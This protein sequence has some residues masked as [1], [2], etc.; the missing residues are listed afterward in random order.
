MHRC[1]TSA[2]VRSNVHGRKNMEKYLAFSSAAL[3]GDGT[4]LNPG[5]QPETT[6][7][8]G[9][10][11]SQR[12]AISGVLDRASLDSSGSQPCGCCSAA[13]SSGSWVYLCPIAGAAAEQGAQGR[14]LGPSNK[15][16]FD[17]LDVLAF[18]IQP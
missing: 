15:S 1:G 10:L 12:G 3:D 17:I 11:H 13:C 14:P 7:L 16:V 2:P 5:H 8:L 4:I 6:S 9:E 18:F